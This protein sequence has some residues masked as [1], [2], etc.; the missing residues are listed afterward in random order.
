MKGEGLAQSF[1]GYSPRLVAWWFEFSSK[2]GV[3]SKGGVQWQEYPAE[4][5]TYNT[6]REVQNEFQP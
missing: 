6:S 5:N 2:G 3:P 1:G 4:Q